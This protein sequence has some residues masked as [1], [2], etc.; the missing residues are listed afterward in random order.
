MLANIS[1]SKQMF[2]LLTNEEKFESTNKIAVTA[3]YFAIASKQSLSVV[4][5]LKMSRILK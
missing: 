2:W 4:L 5:T 3:D 1:L